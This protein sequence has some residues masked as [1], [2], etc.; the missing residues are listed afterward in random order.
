MSKASDK[1]SPPPSKIE[2]PC[3][4]PYWAC[5]CGHEEYRKAGE[6]ARG[7]THIYREEPCPVC[8]RGMTM[9][10]DN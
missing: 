8:K 4:F 3:H 1:P 10:A 9:V 2:H 7:T 5:E 6:L